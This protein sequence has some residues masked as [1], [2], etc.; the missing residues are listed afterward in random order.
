[1][2]ILVIDDQSV[3]FEGTKKRILADFPKANCFFTDKLRTLIAKLQEQKFDLILC[4]LEFDK[5]P[6]IDGFY[7]IK[8]ILNLEPRIKTIAYTNYNSYRIMNKAIKSGFNSFLYKGASASEFSETIKGVL[9]NE[10]YESASMKKL[11]KHRKEFM[12]TVFSDSLYG[13]SSLSKRELELVLFSKQTTNKNELS[14]KMNTDPRTIDTYFQRVIKKL[15]LNDRKEVQHFCL[16][17]YD[18]ILKYV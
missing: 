15:S 10:V 3:L 14:E 17:F 6:E 4:D 1:M 13:I 5:D 9:E 16:E 11:R 12:S 8:T 7:I 18:E 2:N